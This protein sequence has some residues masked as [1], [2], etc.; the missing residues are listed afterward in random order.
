[1]SDRRPLFV[2]IPAPAADALDRAAFERR[3]SKQ[4][5]VADLLA[6]HLQGA[7]ERVTVELP[8]QGLTVGRAELRPSRPAEVLTPAEAAALLQVPEAVVIELAQ[9][10]ELPGRRV[11]D[12]WRFARAGLL[13]WLGSE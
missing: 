3:V 10:G 6:H 13:R 11:G 7:P 8:D 1:M 5:L 12:E 4:D 2:R 9:A